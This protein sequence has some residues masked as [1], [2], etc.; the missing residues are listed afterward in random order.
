MCCFQTNTYSSLNNHLIRQHRNDPHF[1]VHCS[2][3]FC[4]YSSH[5]WNAF[6]L[7]VSRN[8]KYIDRADD[9]MQFYTAGN[10][11][12]STSESDN[13]DNDQ[14]SVHKWF[15]ASY[16]LKLETSHKLSHHALNDVVSSTYM[17]E[18][19]YLYTVQIKNI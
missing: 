18:C 19:L 14:S 12:E 15:T 9:A 8:H 11:D 16:L 10:S 4:M 17:T 1:I 6:K 5:S 7:H 3:P 2:F 13:E